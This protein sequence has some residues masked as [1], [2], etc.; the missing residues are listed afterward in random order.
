MFKKTLIAASLAMT[1]AYSIA[2]PA[3]AVETEPT[4]IEA[5]Q[6][7]VFKNV[8]VFN[9]T[10]NK[11]YNNHSVIVNGN[12]IT[13]I[14]KGDADIP[15]DAKV[16]DGEGRTLMPALID[17]HMHLTI[18]KGLLGTDDMRWTEIAI[19]GQEFAEMYLDM[20][21]GTVRDVGGADGS[22][23]DMERDGRL[24][25]VPRIYASG[26]PIAPIGSH[27]DVGLQSRRLTDS[28][29]NLEILNIMTNA[30]GVDEIKK[31]ARYQ[32]RQGGQFTKVFQSGGVSSKF[33]PWQYN[34]Y[35]DDE[36]K[37]AVAIAESY[38]SYVATHVYSEQAMHQALDLGVKTLEHGF[39]FKADMAEK[40][41]KEGAFI[42]TNLTAFSPDLATIPVV[43]DPLIQKKLASAQAAFGSYQKEMKAAEDAGFDRRAFNVDC[44][45]VADTCAKQ[46]AH[47]IWL[48]ADMFGNFS[49]LRAMTSTSGRI[50]A[51][52]MQ[53]WIDPYS[54]AKL[55]VIEVGAY[56]DILLID[57]NP[58]EDITLVGGRDT[59]FGET[60]DAKKDGSHLTEMDLIMKD[61]KIFKN[62]L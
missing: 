25:E 52:L 24:K 46:I 11:L 8:N 3:P 45:G 17:A 54:D 38:G 2:A 59:W 23:T 37:A 39:M 12:K 60:N 18:P 19:H 40:F 35:L 9:G 53:P 34:S 33:D 51:E 5:P 62:T 16:I 47:E 58:L 44:V 27:A 48:N 42:A 26:A 41:N 30:N 4:A 36:M 43:Q 20:G 29:Q 22:W 56:A 13:A 6:T 55:G 7:V 61:G 57:G 50:S 10:E 21:F 31:Q 15:T 1:A 49:A 28:P 32:Y 14:T